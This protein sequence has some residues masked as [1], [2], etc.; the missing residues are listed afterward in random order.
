MAA[1]KAA[2]ATKPARTESPPTTVA[3]QVPAS[4]ETKPAPPA[5]PEPQSAPVDANSLEGEEW[6]KAKKNAPKR[7]YRVRAIGAKAEKDGRSK[8]V[9]VKDCLDESEA[10]QRFIVESQ[11]P[12]KEVS[13]YHY[14]AEVAA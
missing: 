3:Y 5:K 9:V 1:K 10:I 2:P 6:M 4:E 11:I 12:D 13:S 7:D 8:P 14:R